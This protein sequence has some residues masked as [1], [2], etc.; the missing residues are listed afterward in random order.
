[1]P[2]DVSRR[3]VD[4]TRANLQECSLFPGRELEVYDDVVRTQE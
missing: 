4:V 3:K 1:M 2:R